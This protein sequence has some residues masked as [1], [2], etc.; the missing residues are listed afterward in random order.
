MNTE[1][2]SKVREVINPLFLVGGSVRD[3]L[4]GKSPKDYDFCTPLLPEEIE[5]RIKASGRRAYL[6][7]KRFGTIGAKFDEQMVE[8]TTFRSETYKD[9]NRKPDVE[10]VSDLTADLSRRDFTINAIAMD[11]T[12]IHDPFYGQK[13]LKDKIIRCVGKP[14]ERFKEDPL[15]MLRVARFKSQLC[16]SVEENTEDM[17]KQ[18]NYKI[19]E[20]SKERW[21]AELDKI[22]V[23]EYPHMG[24][25]FLMR[26]KLMNF[27]MPELAL[28][29][30]FDQQNPHHTLNLWVHTLEVVKNVPN[31]IELR[32]AAL[33]HDIGKPFVKAFK[34]E[35]HYNYHKHD[36]LGRELVEKLALYLR[37]SNDRRKNVMSLVLTHMEDSSPLRK[38]DMEAK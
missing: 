14:N 23:S 1:L 21:V 16:F 5:A 12:F 30:G 6:T 31:D 32:W 25:N 3:E 20:I 28:Q 2:F 27:I 37:W 10:F 26:T 24:L 11:D 9:G 29:Y 38:A 36:I 33:L 4:L 19:L 34:A 22:L 8:I 13:D 7:G 18:L 35:N 15:R 17:C